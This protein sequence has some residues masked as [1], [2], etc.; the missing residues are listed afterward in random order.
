MLSNQF[1]KTYSQT[2]CSIHASNLYTVR[3]HP[4][5]K[6]GPFCERLQQY[7]DPVEGTKE[8]ISDNVMIHYLLNFAGVRFS[9]AT[10]MLRKEL[11]KGTLT[12]QETID[13]LCEYERNKLSHEINGPNNNTSGALLYPHG[14]GKNLFCQ[15]CKKKGHHISDCPGKKRSRNNTECWHCWETGHMEK[16][17]P[18]KKTTDEF[19]ATRNQKRFGKKG[20]AMVANGDNTEQSLVLRSDLD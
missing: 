4:G 2:Q 14:G 8:E 7:R 18:L 12:L 13:E 10:H 9:E 6:I 3:P 15:Y 11:N 16:D 5:E 20:R 17:C 19:K 1:N